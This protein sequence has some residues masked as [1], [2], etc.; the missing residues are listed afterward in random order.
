MDN[1]QPKV[2]RLYRLEKDEA[3]IRIFPELVDNIEEKLLSNGL[4]K[5][6][7]SFSRSGVLLRGNGG[8][9]RVYR[10]YSRKLTSA[11]I[12]DVVLWD[13]H[14]SWELTSVIL[15]G[16]DQRELLNY[17]NGIGFTSEDPNSL[18]PERLPGNRRVWLK[19]IV[20]PTEVFI[21]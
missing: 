3:T 4:T 19:D 15:Q 12:H 9:Q 10:G 7:S 6:Y 11:A 1:E 13:R 8:E 5:K 2:D 17:L 20:D 14:N 21:I 16:G 18:F